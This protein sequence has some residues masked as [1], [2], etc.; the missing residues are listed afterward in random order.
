MTLDEVCLVLESIAPLHLAQSWDNVGLLAGDGR[1]DCRSLLLSIDL[2]DAVLQEA[3][4]ER[5]ALLLV[6]HPPLFKPISRLQ[7][8]GT[9]TD[10]RVW[11]AIRHD[12]AIYSMHTA[13]D[14]ATP[15]TND[16]LA[17]LCGATDLQPFEFV[18]PPGQDTKVVVFVPEAALDTVAAAMF[19][20][21]GGRI[22]DYQRCSF[23]TP[24][25]GTFQ[26]GDHSSPHI[27]Q[28][29]RD[30]TV[31]EIRLEVVVPEQALAGVVAAIQQSH[32]YEEPAFDIYPLR[33]RPMPGI[34]RIGPLVQPRPLAALADDLKHQVPSRA[35]QTVGDPRQRITRVAVCAGAAG[36][37][38]RNLGLGS[39]DCVITG[40]I[41]HHDA[42]AVQRC[43]AAAI[44]LGHWS[45]ERPVLSILA[46]QLAERLPGVGIAISAQDR[47]PFQSP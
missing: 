11:Q 12:L 17:A 46:Q 44:A 21:G 4:A 8:H 23:R 2:T 41:H 18:D 34:G 3:L 19:A 28:A 31:S 14:A 40:E 45:S 20:G 30:E 43:G 24:G 27:G 35:L 47:C 13:L 32:P 25:S 26:G 7:A 38:L 10:A 39:G 36:S 22:G 15:G 29:G 9:G 1:A 33:K 6:Y 16:A 5:A 37:A 42:L